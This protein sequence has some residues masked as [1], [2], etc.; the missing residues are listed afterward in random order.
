M[1]SFSDIIYYNFL[2]KAAIIVVILGILIGILVF[3]YSMDW[4]KGVQQVSQTSIKTCSDSTSCFEHCGE[5]V[6][7]KNNLVCPPENIQCSC[8]NST[9]QKVT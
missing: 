5:C 4:I 1:V 9:C 6:S 8:I 2:K 3:S 7:I